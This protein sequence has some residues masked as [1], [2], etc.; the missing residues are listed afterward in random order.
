[1]HFHAPHVELH[2]RFRLGKYSRDYKSTELDAMRGIVLRRRRGLDPA[3]VM[4]EESLPQSS[5][6]GQPRSAPQQRWLFFSRCT[7]KH[8][9][10]LPHVV[11][12]AMQLGLHFINRQS[13]SLLVRLFFM[14][15]DAS[16]NHDRLVHLPEPVLS[17]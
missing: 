15:G 8:F 6:F 13:E 14:L 4:T 12:R 11:D 10:G 3:V 16:L 7:V 9:G 1:M 2:G 17:A 5:S